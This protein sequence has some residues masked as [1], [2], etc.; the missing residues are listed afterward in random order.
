MSTC[1]EWRRAWKEGNGLRGEKKRGEGKGKEKGRRENSGKR[2]YPV[3]TIEKAS[4]VKFIL[5][6]G[7]SISLLGCSSMAAF[8]DR[9]RG[10]PSC[11]PAKSPQR[12]RGPGKGGDAK[13]ARDV[14][15]DSLTADLWSDSQATRARVPR[16]A[17]GTRRDDCVAAETRR[18]DRV[19]RERLN[20]W[21][22]E[23]S[24]F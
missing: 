15:I 14:S 12:R 5:P 18:M 7:F 8:N 11:H 1:V 3:L 23:R 16:V 24:G 13:S 19:N 21:R 20:L 22:G 10:H 9:H 17:H 2:S 6:A 4:R